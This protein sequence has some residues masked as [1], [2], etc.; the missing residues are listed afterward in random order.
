METEDY[1][2]NEIGCIF[3]IYRKN[4]RKIRSDDEVLYEIYLNIM[5]HPQI[6]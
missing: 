5:Y 6:I 4:E 3:Q 2:V 1:V